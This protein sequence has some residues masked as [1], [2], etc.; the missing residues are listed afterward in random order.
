M[1]IKTLR[2]STYVAF[3]VAMLPASAMAPTSRDALRQP[4]GPSAKV[5]A[6]ISVADALPMTALTPTR[7]TSHLDG[8]TV[9]SHISPL[10]ALDSGDDSLEML[11]LAVLDQSAFDFSESLD[12]LADPQ[13]FSI[14]FGDSFYP[15][16]VN[17]PAAGNGIIL[18]YGKSRRFGGT[19]VMGGTGASG[20]RGA[21]GL[22]YFEDNAPSGAD[23]ALGGAGE[24]AQPSVVP[25]PAGLPLILL[26][27]G[28]LAFVARKRRA[29]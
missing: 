11:E 18:P 14:G 8:R 13:I 19:N 2:L 16:A 23:P 27:L 25:L 10:L 28:T 4:I 1:M 3:A 26:G 5:T 29:A 7:I 21:S 20:S 15:S 12:P 17:S 22:D 6:N 9:L 24:A